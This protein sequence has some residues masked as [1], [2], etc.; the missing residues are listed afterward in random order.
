MADYDIQIKL[1]IESAKASSQLA[2]AAMF[3]PVFYVRELV[4][5]GKDKPLV[6]NDSFVS[7]WVAFIAAI[8]LAHTYQITATKLI[9]TEG[10]L[11]F[12]LFPRTQYWMMVLALVI[13]LSFFVN[14]AL[15]TKRGSVQP[16]VAAAVK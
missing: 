6:I 12:P 14:G 13:G 11:T 3:L 2:T 1:W 9:A 4:A 16:Q 15:H 10:V 5:I 7:C 8:A